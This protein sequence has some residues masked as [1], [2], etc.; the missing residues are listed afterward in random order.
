MHE[1]PLQECLER[2]K[3]I[4]EILK[5]DIDYI[6]LSVTKIETILERDVVTR[7][8]FEPIRRIVY[9]MVGVILTAVIV[10]IVK[11]VVTK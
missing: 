1:E 6:K 9:G 3:R 2:N 8:E 11:L 10:A 4:E 5:K 7:A